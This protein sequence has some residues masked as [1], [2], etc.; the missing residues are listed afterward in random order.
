MT[1]RFES[2]DRKIESRNIEP[3]NTGLSNG[4]V[5]REFSV[6]FSVF[7]G[8]CGHIAVFE[9]ISSNGKSTGNSKYAGSRAF[10]GQV[11]GIFRWIF[12]FLQPEAQF[13][14]LFPEPEN[15]RKQQIRGLQGIFRS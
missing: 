10:S 3:E 11:F 14:G 13:S 9:A 8:L 7:S 12:R 5:C 6:R 1:F 4:M 2:Q 15:D